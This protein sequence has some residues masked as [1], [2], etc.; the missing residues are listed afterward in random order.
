MSEKWKNAIDKGS[1]PAKQS[2][3]N[4]LFQ[5]RDKSQIFSHHS[6][7]I[8]EVDLFGSIQEFF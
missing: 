1:V 7:D 3:E 8:S 5:S 6:S 4:L 2:I